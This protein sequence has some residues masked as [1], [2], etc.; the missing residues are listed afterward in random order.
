MNPNS[1]RSSNSHTH[2]IK[3]QLAN[4]AQQRVAQGIAITKANVLKEIM[5]GN[6]NA[7]PIGPVSIVVFHWR[8]TAAIERIMIMVSI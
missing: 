6:V 1:L 5:N 2:H 3:L 4:L 7:F 8:K